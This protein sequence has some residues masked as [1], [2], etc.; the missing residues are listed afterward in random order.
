MGAALALKMGVE[1]LWIRWWVPVISQSVTQI[2]VKNRTIL[3]IPT[4]TKGGGG[5]KPQY[6]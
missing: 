6:L 2:T 5:C 3:L 1:R 4:N